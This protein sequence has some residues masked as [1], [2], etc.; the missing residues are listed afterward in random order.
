MAGQIVSSGATHV[1]S[2]GVTESGDVVT[3][4]GS[5]LIVSSGGIAIGATATNGGTEEVLAG[6]AA[7]AD[8][9]TFSGTGGTLRLDDVA[10]PANTISGL[11]AGDTIDL[12]GVSL[13][14]G[15]LAGLSSGNVLVVSAAGSAYDLQLD[16]LQD[17]SGVSFRLMS[18]GHGGTAVQAVNGLSINFTYDASVS[19]APA[20]FLAA[21]GQATSALEAF[22]AAPATVNIKL[23]F[24]EIF[25]SAMSPGALGESGFFLD[26]FSYA[27]AL[28]ALSASDLSADQLRAYNTLSASTPES[29]TLWLTTAQE[30]ALGLMPTNGIDFDGA[31]GFSSSV[32]F[33][34][35][36]GTTPPFNKFYFIGVAEHEITEVM[37]RFSLL[38]A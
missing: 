35:A 3:G 38:N 16:P 14:S 19:G 28:S 36:S 27:D 29:G 24:G 15:G 22:I 10:M 6:G 8:A 17:L 18:D 7:S 5:L 33:S 25:G 1:V 4:A 26:S 30:R 32:Q 9:I 20:G 2:S 37:G 31:V 12:A 21:L 11:V 34:F 13:A 23:G